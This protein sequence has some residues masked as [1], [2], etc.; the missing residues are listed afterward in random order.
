MG[1]L[2]RLFGVS[3]SIRRQP[4]R[5][6]RLQAA[7]PLEPRLLM[8]R[9]AV[10]DFTG[11]DLSAGQMS[12]GGWGSFQPG[13]GS[14][15]FANVF[16]G[17]MV[18]ND[19]D[20]RDDRRH[21]DVNGNGLVN[22]TD[23]NLAIARIVDKVRQ[24]Y[25]A[26]DLDIRVNSFANALRFP[27]SGPV[28]ILDDSVTGDVVMIINANGDFR[29]PLIAN[30]GRAPQDPGTGSTANAA[31][32][33]DEIGFVFGGNIAAIPTFQADPTA[34][35]FINFVADTLSHE[36]G[37]TF[38][39]DH[40]AI[41]PADD[42]Q[43]HYILGVPAAG[44]GETRDLSHDFG[45]Q[46]IAYNAQTV[47][48]NGAI[49]TVSQNS[50]AILSQADVLGPAQQGSW[51]AMLRPGELTV[52]GDAAA[53][54][55]SVDHSLTNA[56]RW[57]AKA[58][59]WTTWTVQPI[60]M[61]KTLEVDI[62]NPGI[63][64]INPFDAPLTKI[65]VFGGGSGDTIRIGQTVAPFTSAG[66]YAEVFAKGG[67]GDD[68]IFSSGGNDIL[69]GEGGADHLFAGGG[70]DRLFGGNGLDELFGED[71]IDWLDGGMDAF[72]D[73]L[74]GGADRDYLYT[75]AAERARGPSFFWVIPD[76]IENPDSLDIVIVIGVLS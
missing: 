76:R 68:W 43:T 29:T 39:L 16:T 6:A 37:H 74:D 47:R 57:T 67:E 10:L 49:V 13:V 15:P 20:G 52:M 2:R 69:H 59:F 44:G 58:G 1:V 65:N 73:I 9:M 19:S 62:A 31:N 46:D 75:H 14:D 24:D 8:S 66:A 55:L 64:S 22:A 21:L 50:H 12:N 56:N 30:L 36:M 54:E 40:V 35:R 41:N 42:A 51:I 63:E 48:P 18:D 70:S 3:R 23:A 34:D 7:E 27:T 38:G 32:S 17:A 28:H 61:G 26:Y 72:A 11:T 33:G 53:N 4:V 60:F 71:G 5:K 45:F 25:S